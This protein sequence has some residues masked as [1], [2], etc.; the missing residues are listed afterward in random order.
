MRYPETETQR[1]RNEDADED[2]KE[3]ESAK[4]RY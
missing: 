2:R 1:I 4:N 3:M